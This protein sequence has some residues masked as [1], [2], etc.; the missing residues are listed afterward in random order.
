MADIHRAAHAAALDELQRIFEGAHST[1]WK[2][3]GKQLK[4]AGTGADGKQTVLVSGVPALRA[5]GAFANGKVLVMHL[6]RRREL[7]WIKWTGTR[8][9]V[10]QFKCGALRVCLT[11]ED[12]VATFTAAD[13]TAVSEETVEKELQRVGGDYVDDLKAF[14]QS[15]KSLPPLDRDDLAN[16]KVCTS[17]DL[18]CKAANNQQLHPGKTTSISKAFSFSADRLGVLTFLET[19]SPLDTVAHFNRIVVP[20]MV[21]WYCCSFV[22]RLFN[23]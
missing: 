5:D 7:P 4:L 10:A 1:T 12:H 3:S 9:P 6:E 11:K 16:K 20:T 13:G 8:K 14:W 18:L 22:C 15:I 21:R 2:K 23:K 17:Y 19:L